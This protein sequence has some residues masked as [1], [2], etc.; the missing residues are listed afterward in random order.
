MRDPS[1]IVVRIWRGPQK[2][3]FG[4][5]VHDGQTGH[6]SPTTFPKA[7]LAEANARAF[8]VNLATERT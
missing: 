4:W 8:A 5:F 2:G 6:Q 1:V 7:E 3:R